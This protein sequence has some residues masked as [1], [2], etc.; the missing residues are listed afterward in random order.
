MSAIPALDGLRALAVLGTAAVHLAPGHVPGGFVGVDVF[1]VLSGF[2]IT[3]LLLGEHALRSRI[4]LREFY[5]RRLRRLYPAL[6]AVLAVITGWVLVRAGTHPWRVEL[7][8]VAVS[9]GYVLNWAGVAGHDAPW[10]MD[11]LWSLGVEEQFY[12]VIPVMLIL[13]LGRGVRGRSLTTLFGTLAVCSAV[14]GAASWLVWHQV[15]VSYLG[16]PFHAC[17]LLAGCALGAA[18]VHRVG[19][20]RLARLGRDRR[21]PWLCLVG[22]LALA[23]GIDLD[24]GQAFLWGIPAAS[25][26]AAV[27][28][29][30]LLLSSTAENGRGLRA[31]LRHPVSVQVGRRSYSLYL[32]QNPVMWALT[33]PLH[34]AALGLVVVV[35]LVVT[36][37]L[38]EVSYRFVE[39]RWLPAR[40]EPAVGAPARASSGPGSARAGRAV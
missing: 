34:H 15:G 11:H 19:D 14:L 31:V 18:Y 17:G 23:F 37:V 38:A 6:L 32:W 40:T 27:L 7:A 9:A 30:S 25:A 8:A 24:S 13:V 12:L 36:A 10:Q 33:G 22:L 2:L 3:S 39:R 5:V 35:N 26:L 21:V 29:A 1:F 4:D 20:R 28:V 16:T